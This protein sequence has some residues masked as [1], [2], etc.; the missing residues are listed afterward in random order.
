MTKV[1]A[2]L[3]FVIITCSCSREGVVSLKPPIGE[4]ELPASRA[5]TAEPPSTS[6]A[7]TI[8]EV[9]DRGTGL[10]FSGLG[11]VGS[12]IAGEV[13]CANGELGRMEIPLYDAPDGTLVST[14]RLEGGE[15][16]GCYP[17]LLS[18][19]R[20]DPVGVGRDRDFREISYEATALVYFESRDGYA[21]S[22]VHRLPPGVWVKITDVPGEK[23][24]PWTDLLTRSPKRYYRHEGR[25][26]RAEPSDESPALVTIRYEAGSE[27]SVHEVLPTGQVSGQ[28][29]EFEVV[30]YDGD[31]HGMTRARE[32]AKTGNEWK[33]WLRLVDDSG[34]PMFWFY[35]RD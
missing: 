20:V 16:G 2:I 28:W 1:V 26:L 22:F 14:L 12:E 33:G 5:E 10:G 4:S 21:R 32:P 13:S 17:V 15:H 6:F 34:Q 3:A 29:G 11:V 35:T 27:S 31:F 30:E 8:S 23:L 9:D 7:A 19:D 24:Q 25:I 18:D